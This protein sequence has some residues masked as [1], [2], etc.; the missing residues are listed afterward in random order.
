MTRTKEFE[1]DHF[2]NRFNY[3][4]LCGLE[5]FFFKWKVTKLF[6]ML[7]LKQAGLYF[8]ILMLF[9]ARLINKIT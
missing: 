6:R 1:N 5:K 2:S 3:Y 7:P 4:C 9:E 8:L